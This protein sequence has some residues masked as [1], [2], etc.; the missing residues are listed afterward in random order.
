MQRRGVALGE[1]I[2]AGASDEDQEV[3]LVQCLHRAFGSA[4]AKP[5]RVGGGVVVDDVIGAPVRQHRHIR[6]GRQPGKLTGGSRVPTIPAYDY[7]RSGCIAEHVSE[8]LQAGGAGCGLW[9]RQHRRDVGGSHAD[10][11]VLG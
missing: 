6:S 3:G 7:R 10:Q 1:Y 5:A 4:V 8:L 11:D 9:Q 2:A